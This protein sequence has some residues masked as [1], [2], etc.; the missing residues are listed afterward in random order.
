MAGDGTGAEV[1]TAD[2][3][4]TRNADPTAQHSVIELAINRD[5]FADATALDIYWAPSCGNDVLEIHDDLLPARVP[6]PGTLGVL[7]AGMLAFGL[8]RR[9]R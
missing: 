4:Y 7:A 3:V 6:E 2:F 1:G 9:R 5:L 8:V